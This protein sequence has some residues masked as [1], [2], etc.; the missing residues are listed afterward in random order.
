MTGGN[1]L[2]S[3]VAVEGE[4]CQ[5]ACNDGFSRNSAVD[6]IVCLPSGEWNVNTNR[7]CLGV[8]YNFIL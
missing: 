5:Y 1:V 7:L 3:C 6:D 8:Q 4:T 2:P